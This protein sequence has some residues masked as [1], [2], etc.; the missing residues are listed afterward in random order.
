HWCHVMAAESFSD[1]VLARFL[2]E[3]FVA[4]KVDKEERPEV[5]A[6]YMDAVVRMTGEGGWPL[7]AVLLPD[8]RPFLAA[9]YLPPH[10]R[11]GLPSFRQWLE[12]ALSTW[13]RDRA[14]LEHGRPEAT[15]RGAGD[16]GGTLDAVVSAYRFDVGGWGDGPRFPQAPRI[17][18]LLVDRD[19]ADARR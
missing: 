3:R 1:P 17:E 15:V 7:H 6:F 14:R 10:P 11:Y 8:G 16:L 18:L 2:N 12:G 4:V 13:E 9:L 5:D 19:R